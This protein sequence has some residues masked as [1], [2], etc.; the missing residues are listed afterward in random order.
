MGGRD[1]YGFFPDASSSHPF[2]SRLANCKLPFQPYGIDQLR[3]IAQS[4]LQGG[5]KV[6]KDIAVEFAARKVS[7][8]VCGVRVQGGGGGGLAFLHDVLSASSEWRGEVSYGGGASLPGSWGIQGGNTWI[9]PVGV[10]G[11]A[12]HPSIHPSIYLCL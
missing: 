5:A 2:Y 3:T 10:M 11:C 8:N 1:R 6:F 12:I 7:P 9:H 4:R